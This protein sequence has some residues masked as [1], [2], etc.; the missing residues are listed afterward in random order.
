MRVLTRPNEGGPT[1]QA[2]ALWH[3]MAARGVSTLLVT[4]AVAAGEAELRPDAHGVPRVEWATAAAGG[5][6]AGWLE[7]PELRRGLAPFADLRAAGRLRALVRGWRPD[8]VHTHTSKAGWLGRR[9]ARGS[10]AAVVHTFHGHV[11][12]DYFPRPFAWALARLERHMARAT[13]A[14]VAVSESCAD[15]LAAAGVAPRARFH[16]VRPAVPREPLTPRDQ[17]RAE[18][19]LPGDGDV[20][21]CVGRLVPIKRVSLFLAAMRRL[22]GMRG[23]VVGS[24][25]LRAA[26]LATAPPNVRFVGSR[27]DIARLLAAYDVLALPSRREGYPLVAVEAWRAGV[28]VAGFDVPGVRDAVT[29]GVG[30]L[31]PEGAGAAGLAAAI[32]AARSRRCHGPVR[33]PSADACDPIAA[34][35]QLLAI[36]ANARS[37]RT[38]RI[39]DIRKEASPT[40]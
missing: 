5:Q 18:L 21:A 7:L 29:A 8:V 33:E 36:Y 10:G 16:V 6:A 28:P 20:V 32:A 27:P 38:G 14:L 26:L 37:S 9:A 13:D 11:L 4:G 35:A 25:P 22:P 23:D 2:I 40:S 1:R 12:A 15:E 19:G 3:A 17:A 34:A 30:D 39:A 31:A 24:G